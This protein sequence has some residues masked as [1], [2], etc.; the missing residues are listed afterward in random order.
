MLTQTKKMVDYN[1]VASSYFGVELPRTKMHCN[2]WKL[3]SV[4]FACRKTKKQIYHQR[5]IRNKPYKPSFW[6]LFSGLPSFFFQVSPSYSL[7]ILQIQASPLTMLP[8]SLFYKT[9]PSQNIFLSIYP[10]ILELIWLFSL[11]VT[12]DPFGFYIHFSILISGDSSCSLTLYKSSKRT[13]YTAQLKHAYWKNVDQC[14][15]DVK[16]IKLWCFRRWQKKYV[17]QVLVALGLWLQL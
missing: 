11:L 7:S 17:P 5:M 16:R 3:Y 12:H 6:I 10:L 1:V 2:L 13:D 4:K 14:Q 9:L 15:L 8:Q